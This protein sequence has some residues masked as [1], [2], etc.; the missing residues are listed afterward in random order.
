[1]NKVID[2][3]FLEPFGRGGS[4]VEAFAPEVGQEIG[5]NMRGLFDVDAVIAAE[6]IE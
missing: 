5:K 4:K 2:D 1:M 3:D 6:L